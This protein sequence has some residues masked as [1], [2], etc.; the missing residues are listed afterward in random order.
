MKLTTGIGGTFIFS[1]NPKELADWY[2]KMF[3]FNFEGG[4]S[5]FY[6]VFINLDQ[7]DQSKKIDFHFAIMKG[8]ESYKREVKEETDNMY[9]DQNYMLNIRTENIENLISHLTENGV[10]IIKTEDYDYGKFAWVRDP[11]GNRIELYQP[12]FPA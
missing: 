2:T 6:Q 5:A 7:E 9:G 4:G 8:N 11:E 1:E 10:V 3:G 12:L